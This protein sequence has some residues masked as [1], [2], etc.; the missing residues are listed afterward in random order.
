[1]SWTPRV[2]NC[3]A[4]TVD[5]LTQLADD[6][7]T[8]KTTAKTISINRLNE[9]LFRKGTWRHPPLGL[10]CQTTFDLSKILAALDNLKWVPRLISV[11]FPI[12][13]GRGLCVHPIWIPTQ[14]NQRGRIWFWQSLKLF[15]Q[16]EVMNE[17]GG[18][19]FK[20]KSLASNYRKQ[21]PFSTQQGRG[22][23]RT[24]VQRHHSGMVY[25]VSLTQMAG[26]VVGVGLPEAWS[27]T[28]GWVLHANLN[29]WHDF[30]AVC[31]SNWNEMV[32]CFWNNRFEGRHCWELKNS[33][34]RGS[35]FNS[36]QPFGNWWIDDCLVFQ[37]FSFQTVFLKF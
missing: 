11:L 23:T 2:P 3:S 25:R 26:V 22:G 19:N 13:T 27:S 34:W 8:K 29:A 37:L 12:G 30:C 5:R 20:T 35:N 9:Q 4:L 32:F 28:A 17:G 31:F 16:H 6:R 1:M 7:T 36:M 33:V 10:A 15:T 24:C 21:V 18:L 14:P